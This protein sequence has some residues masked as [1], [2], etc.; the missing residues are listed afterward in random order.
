MLNIRRLMFGFQ[1]VPVSTSSVSQLGEIEVLNTINK[2]NF[3]NG[4]N[5]SPVVTETHAD[6]GANRLQNKDLDASNTDFVDPTDTTKV[7]DF[8]VSGATTG[9]ELTLAG[10][11]TAN[12]TV[13]LPDATDTLVGRNT[14]DTLTNKTIA[15]GSNTITGLTNTNLSGSAG[16]TG[17]NLASNTV[18][19]SNL[20]QMASN[21]LKGNNTGS[22]A[23]PSDLTVSQVNTMLGI[24]SVPTSIGALDSQSANSNGLSLVSNVLSTQSASSTE[25][26]LVNTGTQSFSGSK[27]FT[28]ALTSDGNTVLGNSTSSQVTL[29]AASSTA[30][31]E[32]LGGIRFTTNAVSG[33]Y[34]VDNSTTDYF[35]D[36]D[37]SSA[38]STIT[39]PSPTSGR[40]IYVKDYKG[41]SATHN[42]TIDPHSS[43]TIDGASSATISSNYGSAAYYSDGTNWYSFGGSSG[44]GGSGVNT[45]GTF[46]SQSA[47]SNGLVIVSNDLYAQ[48]ASA[49]NPGMVNTGAQ[50]FAGNKTFQN[51][52]LTNEV[53]D[54]GSGISIVASNNEILLLQT[55]G[56]GTIEAQSPGGIA[57]NKITTPSSVPSGYVAIYPKSDNNY[58]IKPSGGSEAQL[59]TTLTSNPTNTYW[60]G[61]FD[62]TNFWTGGS[63]IG[64]ADF[65]LTG[66]N[67]TLNTRT[68]NNITVSAAGSSLPG[69]TFT[70][71]SSSAV[72]FVSF[73]AFSSTGGTG[74]CSFQLT[75]GTNVVSAPMS[76]YVSGGSG[77]G[78]SPVTITGIYAPGTSSSVT[79]KLQQVTSGP[80]FSIGLGEAYGSALEMS[81]V[82]IL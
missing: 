49:T 48:S 44:G 60:S 40:V 29:G 57:I 82:R 43:E 54:R 6:Q 53:S 68:S 63:T 38:V 56:N 15:A 18:G 71:A 24:S 21:T 4:T 3:H 45:I 80:T 39:L 67:D 52:I 30:V 81:I 35:L 1:V 50:T 75:D 41:A 76:V 5:A 16:I 22:S 64:Y 46:D 74:W 72:Y 17:A 27:T 36:V 70:P 23:S 34:S 33:S 31:H 11:Q 73:L 51:T 14:T 9:T 62:H 79:L 78:G 20:S 66:G 26:G 55:G 28:G 69:I 59:L 13:T 32:F 47:S 25:P 19:N 12:R 2:I 61:Y 7:I 65:G 58:Y 8:S 37:V 42:I 10:V 77:S